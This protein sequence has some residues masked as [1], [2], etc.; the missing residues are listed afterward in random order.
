MINFRELLRLGLVGVQVSVGMKAHPFRQYFEPKTKQIFSDQFEYI[1][2]NSF[3]KIHLPNDH[4][5]QK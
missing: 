3:P 2:K 5:I 1:K 4:N